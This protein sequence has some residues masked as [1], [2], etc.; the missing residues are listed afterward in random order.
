MKRVIISLLAL[1]FAA[2]A[3]CQDSLQLQIFNRLQPIMARTFTP[4]YTDVALLHTPWLQSTT[5]EAK[6]DWRNENQAEIQELGNGLSQGRFLANSLKHLGQGR[7]VEGSVSYLRGV[8]KNVYMNTSSDWELLQPYV[9]ADTVGGNLQ[10]E[11]YT[12]AGRYAGRIGSWEYGFYGSYRALHEYRQTDPRPRN[13][14]SDLGVR[15]SAG[16]SLGSHSISVSVAYRRYHQLQ[17]VSFMN[18]R[19]ANTS[20]FHLTGLGTHYA[21]LAGSG[22]FTNL[23][24]R[25]K[26]FSVAAL[27]LP[28][29]ASGFSAGVQYDWFKSTRHLPNQNEVPYSEL[30]TQTASAFAAYR[31]VLDKF[32]YGAVLSLEYELREGSEA[33]LPSIISSGVEDIPYLTLYRS[34]LPQARLEGVLQLRAGKAVWSLEPMVAAYSSEARRLDSGKK[35]K[36]DDVSYGLTAG[37]TAMLGK[38]TTQLKFYAGKRAISLSALAHFPAGRMSAFIRPSAGYHTWGSGLHGWTGNIGAG[39]EF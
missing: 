25:G 20:E 3:Y 15:A 18:P 8:K 34:K 21:R 6:Y 24:F 19:G 28:K 30:L 2:C 38:A 36:T 10:T 29:A 39:I 17:A 12:F 27:F 16:R 35:A 5:V 26:G 14:S 37:W 32:S 11:Q 7:A 13:I 33:I 31:K 9:M 1:G 22:S 4:S 23:R